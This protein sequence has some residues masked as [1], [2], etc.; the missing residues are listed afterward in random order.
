MGFFK[1]V[2][3]MIKRNVNFK[4]LVKVGGQ[5]LA[6]VPGGGAAA[7]IVENLQAQHEQRNQER[8]Q[9]AAVAAQ[10]AGSVTYVDKG[11]KLGDVLQAAAG[12]ALSATGS[13]LLEDPAVNQQ[14][15]KAADSVAM[16]WLKKNWWKLAAGLIVIPVAF[17]GIKKLFFGGSRRTATYR[18]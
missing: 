5:V 15:A 11:V 8:E 10:P 6:V 4:N 14:A 18:R 3:R 2:G 7:G 17:W 16:A 13:A 1:K 9:A 12:G